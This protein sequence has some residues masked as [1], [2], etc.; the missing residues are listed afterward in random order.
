MMH[1]RLPLHLL[2]A[3]H[4]LRLL[5]LRP[6]AAPLQDSAWEP[7]HLRELWPPGVA[8]A[9]PADAWQAPP[10]EPLGAAPLPQGHLEREP[11]DGGQRSAPKR[12]EVW[13]RAPLHFPMLAPRPRVGSE[14]LGLG[15][16]P[17]HEYAGPRWS[18]HGRDTPGNRIPEPRHAGTD[19]GL[20]P[21]CAPS[22]SALG[23]ACSQ[24]T[25]LRLTSSLG[26]AVRPR[27]RSRSQVR[28]KL[29]EECAY[30][31]LRTVMNHRL[32]QLQVGGEESE[33]EESKRG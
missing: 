23:S 30:E 9:M 14:S 12:L 3:A 10:L 27:T 18:V 29:C 31:L 26:S 13:R 20:E 8:G 33:F 16:R 1:H 17:A 22:L 19:I 5:R 21:C 11:Q 7:E 6:L 24:R 2:P 25:R 32:W 4:P 15:T 28:T